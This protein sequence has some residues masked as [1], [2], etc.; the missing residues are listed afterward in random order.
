MHG[1][2]LD[3]ETDNDPVLRNRGLGPEPAEALGKSLP[4][5]F[6]TAYVC[7]SHT[8][9]VNIITGYRISRAHCGKFQA[10]HDGHR[11]IDA[12]SLKRVF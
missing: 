8:S 11:R 4:L 3:R 10:R 5:I 2:A 1:K 6:H 12:T 7:F 9:K